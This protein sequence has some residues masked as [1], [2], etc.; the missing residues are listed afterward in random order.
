MIRWPANVGD[1]AK[2]KR[3]A[4]K[5]NANTASP[6]LRSRQ[7]TLDG[8]RR[9][10]GSVTKAT[11]LSGRRCDAWPQSSVSRQIVRQLTEFSE[12][13]TPARSLFSEGVD[14]TGPFSDVRSTVSRW[15]AHDAPRLGAALAF[16]TLLSLA[17][18][19]IF[20]VAI[21]SMLFGRAEVEQNIIQQAKILLGRTGADAIQS[22]IASAREPAQGIRRA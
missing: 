4:N 20:M 13:R 15:M 12:T 11:K 7:I 5:S 18:L 22:L 16:Y 10:F 19:L 6:A 8:G 2:P 21:L 3:G 1:C 17:P 9:M 14:E